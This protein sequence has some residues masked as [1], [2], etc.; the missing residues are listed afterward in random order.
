MRLS[1]GHYHRHIYHSESADQKL[2]EEVDIPE[3]STH[4]QDAHVVEEMEEVK[5]MDLG[6]GAA[7]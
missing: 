3:G 4:E 5:V 7:E 1:T 6:H 2:G